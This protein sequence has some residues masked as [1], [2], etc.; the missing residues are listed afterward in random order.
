MKRSPPA[1]EGE[2]RL[3]ARAGDTRLTAPSPAPS[4][5]ARTRIPDRSLA[6]VVSHQT[7]DGRRFRPA[8]RARRSASRS[9]IWPMPRPRKRASTDQVRDDGVFAR[10]SPPHRR[11]RS[12]PRSPWR[13][14]LRHPLPPGSPGHRAWRAAPA[15]PRDK[16]WRRY[17]LARRSPVRSASTTLSCRIRIRPR[18]D[19]PGRPSAG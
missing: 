3:E 16:R 7:P 11:R 1:E 18:P 17:G 8:S 10:T 12:G 9:N 15:A 13:R 14:A 4:R 2:D 6:L 19:P 5:K